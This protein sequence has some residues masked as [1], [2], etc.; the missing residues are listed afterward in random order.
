M[1]WRTNARNQNLNRDFTKLD[2]PEIR[3]L[4]AAMR[5]WNPDLYLDLHV[6]DGADYQY[7]ITFGGNG[8]GAWSP[9]IGRWIEERYRPAVSRALEDWG[10]FPFSLVFAAN[11]M[12]MNDGFLTWTGSPRYSNGYG[13]ARQLPAILVENHSLK[14]YRQRVLGTYVLLRASMELLANEAEALRGAVQQ[15]RNLRP[16]EI[17]LVFERAA[18]EAGNTREF[19]GIRSER[20]EGE[21]SGATVVRWTGEPVTQQLPE[22]RIDRPVVSVEPPSAY[23]LPPAWGDVARRLEAHGVEME[24]LERPLTAA[25]EYYRLPEA[26]LAEAAGWTSNPFEG[27]VRIDPGEPEVERRESTFP[28]GSWRIP[29]DQPLGRLAALLLEPRSPDSFLQWGFF[30]E[31]MNRT[32][33]AESYLMEPLAQRM[34][35]DDPALAEAF[36]ERLRTDAEF[37]ASPAARR[38]WFYERTPYYDDRYRLYP[39]ARLP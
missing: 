1:G 36:R 6:T 30:L 33:Y 20:Y 34:M 38:A 5:R 17:P 2:T 14:P 24:R 8:S 28:A 10:H 39:V 21:A 26:R 11:G 27:R 7:D 23:L 31:I 15:D 18:A 25:V 29:T 3:A 13:D 4:V 35:A 16:G 32:E 22:V 37:A 9:A 12:D 19:L